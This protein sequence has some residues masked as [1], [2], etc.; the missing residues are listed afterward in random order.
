MFLWN[1]AHHLI[2]GK[3]YSCVLCFWFKQICVRFRM[4]SLNFVIF[5]SKNRRNTTDL[6]SIRFLFTLF[7]PFLIS[8]FSITLL[9]R[10]I[11]VILNIILFDLRQI[12]II[13]KMSHLLT[14][15]LIKCFSARGNRFHIYKGNYINYN[16]FS[17]LSFNNDDYQKI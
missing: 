1:H 9:L 16:K 7:F 3:S 13:R 14:V 2:L 12:K 4:I 5:L 10:L 6:L 17:C 11:Y 15:H 8:Y